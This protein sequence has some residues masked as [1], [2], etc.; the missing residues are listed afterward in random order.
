MIACIPYPLAYQEIDK[1][2][3]IKKIYDTQSV[4]IDSQTPQRVGIK[5]EKLYECISTEF[6][7][8]GWDQDKVVV[9][10]YTSSNYQQSH[11]G[12]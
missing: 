5:V 6:Q 3:V 8:D 1:D 10:Y 4:V 11:F 7:T 2:E 12:N 9:Y